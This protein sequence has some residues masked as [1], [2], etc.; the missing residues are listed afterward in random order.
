[1]EQKRRKQQKRIRQIQK[2]QK[3]GD[4]FL[5]ILTFNFNLKYDSRS[6]LIILYWYVPFIGMQ[7]RSSARSLTVCEH[8]ISF[9]LHIEIKI[10]LV[11][12]DENINSHS[13][14][15]CSFFIF[16]HCT[17]LHCTTLYY[18]A[19]IC[20]SLSPIIF[21]LRKSPV[22]VWCTQRHSPYHSYFEIVTVTALRSFV[23][24]Q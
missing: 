22:C 12:K 11:K 15:L 19:K 21:Y 23:L 8:P 14:L 6:N 18:S 1:M 9:C 17:T 13:L 7:K 16:Q 5:K 2:N 24:A 3:K 20:S 10:L 4:F